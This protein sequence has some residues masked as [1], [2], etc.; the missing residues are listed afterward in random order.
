LVKINGVSA[1]AP[2]FYP[3]DN[4]DACFVDYPCQISINRVG[5][6]GLELNTD[7]GYYVYFDGWSQVAYMIPNT[8]ETFGNIRGIVDVLGNSL[9]CVT[10]TNNETIYTQSLCISDS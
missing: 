4:G 6:N 1:S 9:G 7:V 2:W 8:T 3:P 10:L 5:Y